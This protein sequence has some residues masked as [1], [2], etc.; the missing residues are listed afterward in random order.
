MTTCGGSI[1]C[2]MDQV[3]CCTKDKCPCKAVR[4]SSG[5]VLSYS[6][7]A[8]PHCWERTGPGLQWLSSESPAAAG[9]ACLT[10][11][12]GQRV[13]GGNWHQKLASGGMLFAAVDM[14]S[15][16]DGASFGLCALLT[17]KD[18]LATKL[19]AVLLICKHVHLLISKQHP[20]AATWQRQSTSS[21]G[22]IAVDT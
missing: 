8:G 20:R 18:Q 1:I 12:G 4:Y 9:Q 21:L 10:Q 17:R 11:Q 19:Q 5:N 16:A 13:G 22:L 6:L 2:D 15:Q 3:T 14:P 7:M